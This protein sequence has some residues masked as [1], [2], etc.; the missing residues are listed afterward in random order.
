ME[1]VIRTKYVRVDGVLYQLVDEEVP[2]WAKEEAPDATLLQEGKAADAKKTGQEIQK[3]KDRP[4][5][6][7]D[8]EGYLTFNDGQEEEQ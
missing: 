8:E 2:E 3:L 1:N 5:F 6:F 7:Y 4:H